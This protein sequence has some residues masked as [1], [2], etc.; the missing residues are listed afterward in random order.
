M[1]RKQKA[2]PYDSSAGRGTGGYLAKP[3]AEETEPASPIRSLAMPG[4]PSQKQ[5]QA[6]PPDS[7]LLGAILVTL[8]CFWPL[9]IF[10]IIYALQVRP[11]WKRGD[12]AGAK[13]SAAMAEKLTFA[14]VGIFVLLAFFGAIGYGIYWFFGP[15]NRF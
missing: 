13:R 14:S 4:P 10:A 9:G 8:F 12:E 11:R 15:R 6:G 3:D 7:T 2:S 1:A 5:Y